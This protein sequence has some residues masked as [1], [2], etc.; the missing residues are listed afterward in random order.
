VAKLGSLGDKVRWERLEGGPPQCVPADGVAVKQ[1]L[2]KLPK[3]TILYEANGQHAWL[4]TGEMIQV[5]QAWRL[6]DAPGDEDTTKGGG[7]LSPELQ[8]LLDDLKNLDA[9]SPHGQDTPGAN[10]DI[11]RYNLQ[12]AE[13]VQKVLG[14]VKPEERDQWLRQLADC[15]SAAAQSS[16]ETDK[17][18]YQ[19]LLDLEKKT[20]A[21]QPGSAL[22]GY[23]TFREMSADYAVK[24]A[25]VGPE[26]A[27][28]QEQWLTRGNQRGHTLLL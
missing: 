3:S 23:V 17:G 5:G 7:T 13:I 18:V 24:L 22:A 26:F 28:V 8:K 12:R 9:K 25:H 15:L 21:E 6:I 20:V 11:V 4:T 27:K 10:A 2:L 14:L 1:D 16:P 19:Q